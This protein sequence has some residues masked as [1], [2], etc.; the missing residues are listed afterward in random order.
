MLL[1]SP[2]LKLYSVYSLEVSSDVG[3]AGG[4]L[5]DGVADVDGRGNEPGH[6]LGSYLAA[7]MVE[8]NIVAVAVAV[9]V[10]E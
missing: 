6:D 3:N 7:Y 5:G 8:E 1:K 2:R 10:V 9:E 4:Q